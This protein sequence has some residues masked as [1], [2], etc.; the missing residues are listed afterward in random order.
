MRA[1]RHF[2]ASAL[3]AGT[4]DRRPRLG[5]RES[6]ITLFVLADLMTKAYAAPGP[7]Q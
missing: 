5:D 2:Y 1:L 6:K 3:R 4:A 7:S